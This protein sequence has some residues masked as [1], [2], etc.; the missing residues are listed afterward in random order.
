MAPMC[1]P[2]SN[3]LHQQAAPQRRVPAHPARS[4]LAHRSPAAGRSTARMRIHLGNAASSRPTHRL[5]VQSWPHGF[6][7]RYCSGQPGCISEMV[8][9]FR[10]RA[11]AGNSRSCWSH[12]RSVSVF[13]ALANMLS[14]ILTGSKR[15]YPTNHRLKSLPPNLWHDRLAIPGDHLP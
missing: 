7:Y 11:V 12:W 2:T 8:G 5:A 6:H 4:G 9:Y 14:K 10:P 1:N 15:A 3:N 13:R